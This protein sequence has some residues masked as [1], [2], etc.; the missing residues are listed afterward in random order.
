[1]AK[2]VTTKTIVKSPVTTTAAVKESA[3]ASTNTGP[4]VLT[5]VVLDDKSQPISGARVSITPSTNST[6]TNSSGEAQFTLG[7]AIKYDITATAG[8]NTVT[9]PYYVT[10]NGAT[11]LVV[12]PKYVKSVEA[13]LHPSSGILFYSLSTV[14]IVLAVA[15]VFVI[16]WSYFKSK[17]KKVS[18][19]SEF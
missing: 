6:V 3:Q 14:G 15:V 16:V 18:R 11:R 4:V 9:V 17:Y 12:N 1:M 5:V 19:N 10:K 13:Q 7:T 2:T 8:S